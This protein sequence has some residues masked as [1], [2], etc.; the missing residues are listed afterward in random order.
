MGEPIKIDD[1]ARQ[2]IRLAGR[3][4]DTDV[5]I[6]YTG[7]RPGER[8]NETLLHEHERPLPTAIKGILLAAPRAADLG[9]LRRSVEELAALAAAGRSAEA[10]ALLRRVVPEYRPAAGETEPAAASG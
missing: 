7:L 3:Q 6:R 1:L 8:L 2:I 9:L 10:M 4:P 5:A